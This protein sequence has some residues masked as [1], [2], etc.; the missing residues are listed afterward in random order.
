MSELFSGC[1]SLKKIDLHNFNTEN[2]NDMREMFSG[3][4]SLEEVNIYNFNFA[5]I[6]NKQKMFE[7]CKSLK[8]I[9]ISPNQIPHIDNGL[10]K[11]CS[12]AKFTHEN[13]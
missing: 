12:N 4:T 10:I 9:N 7:G 11:E 13:I 3:C 2:V 1:T 5:T 6:N 8:I